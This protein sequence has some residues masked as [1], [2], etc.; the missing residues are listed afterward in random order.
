MASASA[1][2]R[3]PGRAVVIDLRPVLFL[4]GWFLAALAAIMLVPALVDV[5]AGNP[6][7]ATFLT[8][9]LLTLFVG[10]S[11][12]LAT[13]QQGQITLARRQ[14]F[15]LTSAVWV[16]A[17]AFGAL[18]FAL[19]EGLGLSYTDG[20]FEAMSGITTTG[21][22]VMVGLDGAPP[23]ILLWRALL[24][25]VGGVGFIAI[26]VAVLPALRIGG[27]QLF[28]TESS[29]RSEKIV[30]RVAQLAGA[31]LTAYVGLTALCAVAYGLAG[32]GGFDAV[33]HAM[34]TLSTGGYGNYDASFAHFRNPAVEWV[35][36][37]FMTAGGLPFVLYLRAARGDAG[38]LWRDSQVRWYLGTLLVASLAVAVWIGAT[39]AMLPGEA[40]R[41]AAFNVVSVVT[42]TGYASADYATWGTFAAV[43]FFFLL[44]AGACTGS[45]SGGIK[46]FR[47]AVLYEEAVVQLRRLMQPHGAF[48][49]LFN[50][51][52]IPEAVAVAVLAFFF[53]FALC[54]VALTVALSLC[55]LDFVTSLSGA[56]TVLNNVGPGLGTEIGPS[57][58][59]AGLPDAAKWLLAFGML[60]GRL[61]LFTILVLLV[62]SFWRG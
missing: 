25:W 17:A 27:M 35:G 54:T 48:L 5:A 46:Q 53:L 16:A 18:P 2:G 22:T 7:W 33:T 47:Y 23:G 4:V 44:F 39:Q 28:Q 3:R 41:A 8:S 56:A 14:A 59:F 52:P 36:V 12:A 6:D 58:N 30:P 50:G 51:R 55:G 43:A 32:M 13:R 62:P 15:L 1:A 21:S 11:L 61:E 40:L 42:T 57:G 9:S 10:V 34:T 26:G 19:G 37:A 24:Q 20:F 38:A 49:P 60:L 31:I 29:D 45:T